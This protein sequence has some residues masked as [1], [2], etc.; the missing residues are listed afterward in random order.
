MLIGEALKKAR[1][2]KGLTQKQLAE[3]LYVDG[4]LVSKWEKDERQISLTTFVMIM[5]IL[6]VDLDYFKETW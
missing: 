3:M 4:S 2:N 5:D 1:E 6:E